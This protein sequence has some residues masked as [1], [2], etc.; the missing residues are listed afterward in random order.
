MDYN[1]TIAVGRDASGWAIP[2]LLAINQAQE[3]HDLLEYNSG[4][5]TLARRWGT[6]H[7]PVGDVIERLWSSRQPLQLP[8]WRFTCPDV[9]AR[10]HNDLHGGATTSRP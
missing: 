8:W 9:P 5:G 1:S 7:K 10:S 2:D 6:P 3:R 4:T